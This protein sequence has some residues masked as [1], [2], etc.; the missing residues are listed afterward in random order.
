MTSYDTPEEQISPSEKVKLSRL[1]M[2]LEG[3]QVHYRPIISFAR[4]NGT[5]RPHPKVILS[6]IKSLLHTTNFS[7]ESYHTYE[8]HPDLIISATDD[9]RKRGV[10]ASIRENIC[11][12]TGIT[13]LFCSLLQTIDKKMKFIAPQGYYHELPV[14]CEKFGHDFDVVKTNQESDQK[15]SMEHLKYLVSLHKKDNGINK[16][17]GIIIANPTLLGS[18]YSE[19]ELISLKQYILDN[20]I[21][22]IYDMAFADTEYDHSVTFGF[23]TDD[24]IAKN[25]VI[26]RGISKGLNSA[27]LRVGWA[28]GPQHIIA[29]MTSYRELVMGTVPFLNQTMAAAALETPFS[30]LSAC[31]SECEY[32][33][34]LIYSLCED[35]ERKL[36]RNYEFFRKLS[37]P[38]ITPSFRPKSGHSI[39]VNC[40]GV[41]GLK[42]STGLRLI[43][44]LDLSKFFLLEAGV[45]ISPGY[46]I[47]FDDLQFRLSFGPIGHQTTYDASMKQER[48]FAEKLLRDGEFHDF[49]IEDDLSHSAVFSAGRDMIKETFLKRIYGCL[50]NLRKFN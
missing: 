8:D 44:S 15:I 27:N 31:R 22:V 5:R 25:T 20:D 33:V 11:I 39:L 21:F 29:K 47:G 32:R 35:I 6:A 19:F 28:C 3:E 9:F 38:I 7:L 26:F 34:N 46:A 36:R 17:I 43:N 23:A 45:Q 14:W 50:A 18:V 48:L 49:E 12:D 2:T 41:I 1:A 16:R 4:G 10:A 40:G 24:A 42:T 37:A 30:Y 13:S